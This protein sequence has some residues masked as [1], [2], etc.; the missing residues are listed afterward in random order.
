M[1]IRMNVDYSYCPDGITL[2]HVRQGEVEDAPERVAR[3]LLAD[4]RAR[5]DKMLDS[6][7]AVKTGPMEG[8][9]GHRA[10]PNVTIKVERGA[11]PYEVPPAGVVPA[12]P[13]LAKKRG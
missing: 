11:S 13:R 2:K 7:P 6:A 8:R 12:K 10:G 4:G 5:E 1:R 9:Q 3:V